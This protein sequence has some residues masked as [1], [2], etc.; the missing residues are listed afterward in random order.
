VINVDW[1]QANDFCGWVGGRLPTEAE[2]NFAA[3]GGEEQRVYPW[4]TPPDAGKFSGL[5]AVWSTAKLATVGS[6]TAGRAKWNQEDMA[7]NVFEWVLDFYD[8]RDPEYA[9]PQT[10]NDCAY[11]IDARN[12]VCRGGSFHSPDTVHLTASNRS[13]NLPMLDG[14]DPPYPHE[15][16]IRCAR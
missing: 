1:N 10:C 8:N 15:M 3:A 12:R 6:K 7:G 5:Y 2:W 4:S 11:L 16:G 9:P 14:V 13:W